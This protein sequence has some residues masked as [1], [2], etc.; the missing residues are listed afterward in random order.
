MAGKL[1]CLLTEFGLATPA[2]GEFMR[3][4]GLAAL[5]ATAAFA[6]SGVALAQTVNVSTNAG[7]QAFYPALTQSA[8]PFPWSDLGVMAAATVAPGEL[9]ASVGGHTQFTLATT[10]TGS[11]TFVPGSTTLSLSYVPDWAGSL[12][13]SASANLTSDFT[14]S[15][16]PFSGSQSLLNVPLA[17]GATTSNL[18]SSLNSGAAGGNTR[19][20]P[21]PGVDF[22]GNFSGQVGVCP[23][24]TTLASIS[25]DV[26]VG[27]QIQQTTSWAP[28]ITYGDLAWYSTTP[29]YSASDNPVAVAGSGGSISNVFGT[30]TGLS[31]TNGETF[32]YNVLPFVNLDMPIGNSAEAD[33][34]ASLSFD[35]QIFG[36]DLGGGDF[37][38]SN[39]YSLSTGDESFDFN[40]TWF[41]Q[42]FYS[43]PLTYTETCPGALCF[44]SYK[45]PSS[46]VSPVNFASGGAPSDV[47]PLNFLG[48]PWPGGVAGPGTSNLGSLFP[49]GACAPSDSAYAGQCITQVNLTGSVTATPEPSSL[50]LCAFGL[51]CLAGLARARQSSLP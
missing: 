32:F 19:I 40:A 13:T 48:G 47:P 29:T 34:P 5:T 39:L 45:T 28:S 2:P 18:A 33:V 1:P 25:F 23:F 30:P 15:I 43:L 35:G 3:T 10:V 46:S 51:L 41:G 7:V 24:C 44:A 50:L 14:Y 38:P 42:S 21:G 20:A 49:N 36:V 26:N 17:T 16:G 6:L 27:S 37:G 11:E 8:G 22:S 12:T 4:I 31:L 9:D